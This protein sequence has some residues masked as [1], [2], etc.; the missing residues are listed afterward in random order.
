[1]P[2]LPVLA[3]PLVVAAVVAAPWSVAAAT[4]FVK[5]ELVDVFGK[6]IVKSSLIAPDGDIRARVTDPSGRSKCTSGV[7][8]ANIPLDDRVSAYA[9]W[10]DAFAQVVALAGVVLVV[11]GLSRG[12]RSQNL[13][14]R[15]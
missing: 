5:A 7:L 2:T 9:W 11:A 10:G 12:R 1:M 13:P 3:L 14:E 8:A 4:P 15:C 6:G